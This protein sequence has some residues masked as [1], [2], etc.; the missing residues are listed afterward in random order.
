[1]NPSSL[2]EPNELILAAIYITGALKR[3]LPNV[4]GE[5]LIIRCCNDLH[6][7]TGIQWIAKELYRLYFI[8]LA[9]MNLSSVSRNSSPYVSVACI[10]CISLQLGYGIGQDQEGVG[11]GSRLPGLPDPPKSWI[12]WAECQVASDACQPLPSLLMPIKASYAYHETGSLSHYI[13][14]CH[15]HK[16]SCGSTC[17]LQLRE[18]QEALRRIGRAI[19][20]QPLTEA[21]T[22]PTA[23]DTRLR[24]D[25]DASESEQVRREAWESLVA[26]SRNIMP[27]LLKS[28]LD[29]I[30][31]RIETIAAVSGP[32]SS[33]VSA[34]LAALIAVTACW[35]NTTPVILVQA[36]ATIQKQMAIVDTS[37]QEQSTLCS[38]RGIQK[39]TV[40]LS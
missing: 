36:I 17:H 27:L 6:L 1:M 33:T 21:L 20:D 28:K 22:L 13:S 37:A 30:S 40:S 11:S 29:G 39:I 16:L 25:E 31:C 34:D 26:R 19:E 15:K 18:V 35:S 9:L 23:G 32:R 12:E 10:V 24:R 5:E 2:P 7:P 38:V 8:D 3:P 14:F 4:N